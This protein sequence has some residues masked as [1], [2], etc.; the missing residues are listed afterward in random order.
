M[1]NKGRSKESQSV[2]CSYGLRRAWPW[3]LAVAVV[4]SAV[5]FWA[6]F[7]AYGSAVCLSGEFVYFLLIGFL[8]YYLI[9]AALFSVRKKP[10]AP[11][12]QE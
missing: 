11:P 6:P 10:K 12:A 8:F 3:A 9:L 2:G 7:Q 4:I 1:N 5:R